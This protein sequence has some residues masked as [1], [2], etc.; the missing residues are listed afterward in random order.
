M[1][2]CKHTEVEID[3]N[4]PRSL[5]VV[6]S[7]SKTQNLAGQHPPDAADGV[8]TLV[9]GWD[10]DVHVIRGRVGVTEGNHRD[11]DVGSLLDGLGI[12]ARVSD[13][14]Q[15]WLLEGAGD[16]VRKAAGRESTGDSNGA[17]VRGELEDGALAVRTSRDDADIGG[18]IDCDDDAGGEN[19]LLPGAAVSRGFSP[20]PKLCKRARRRSTRFCQC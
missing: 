4:I 13:D 19:D 11:V 6:D 9:V 7:A 15:A 8:T 12:S 20:A 5:A 2:Q 18:I 10:R 14:D 17:G 3:H 1:G 16:V